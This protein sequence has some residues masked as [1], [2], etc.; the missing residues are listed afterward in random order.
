MQQFRVIVWVCLFVVG[1]TSPG[2]ASLLVNEVLADPASDWN[3]DEMTHSRDDEWLEIINTSTSPVDLTG[4]R[5]ASSDT[6]WRYEFSGM[7]GP[8]DVRIIYGSDAYAWEQETG[9]PAFGLRLTNTGATIGLWRLTATDTTLV[10]EVTYSDEDAEDDRSAGRLD[11]NPD[12]WVL[13]DQLNPYDGEA[14]P[15]STGCPPTPGSTNECLTPAHDS[16]WGAVKSLYYG[17]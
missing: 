7:L 17:S 5:V 2:A 10:D 3:G 12:E 1:P 8:G 16:S 15:V 11:E 13:F 9:N 14:P 4:L 6:T